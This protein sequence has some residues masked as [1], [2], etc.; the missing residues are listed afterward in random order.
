MSPKSFRIPINLNGIL[1]GK[2]Q[3]IP[4]MYEFPG[5]EEPETL[6]IYLSKTLYHY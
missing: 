6:I 1:Y 3:N 4:T 2:I 5:L